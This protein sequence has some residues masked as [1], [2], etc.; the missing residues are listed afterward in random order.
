M[1]NRNNPGPSA[2]GRRPLETE[3]PLSEKD[4]QARCMERMR[5]LQSEALKLWHALKEKRK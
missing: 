5:K 2:G 1:I 4:E 3:I